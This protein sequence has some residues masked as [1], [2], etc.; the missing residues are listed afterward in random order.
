MHTRSAFT[1]MARNQV[2]KYMMA[3]AL[4]ALRVLEDKFLS[5][6]RTF[7]TGE[8]FT[9]AGTLLDARSTSA[10]S[11]TSHGSIIHDVSQGQQH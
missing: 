5:D 7:V 9:A 6:T 10:R 3:A 11:S 4:K 1:C 8:E 2:S